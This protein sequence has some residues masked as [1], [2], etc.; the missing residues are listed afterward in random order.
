[1]C[2]KCCF[3]GEPEGHRHQSVESQS[4]LSQSNKMLVNELLKDLAFPDPGRLLRQIEPEVTE[5]GPE[6]DF[7]VVA[8]ICFFGI[9]M[10]L[11]AICLRF[12]PTFRSLCVSTRRENAMD[13]A[14]D[15]PQSTLAEREYA[16][17]ELFE[18]SQVTMVSNMTR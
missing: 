3:A 10:I 18:T 14:R 1:L 4:S 2:S 5:A 8:G 7:N 9:L 12:N 6:S 15:M 11:M 16:I 13:K 17:L